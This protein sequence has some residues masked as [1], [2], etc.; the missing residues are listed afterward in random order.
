MAPMLSATNPLNRARG[1][2]GDKSHDNNNEKDSLTHKPGNVAY[3]NCAIADVVHAHSY[4]T[5]GNSFSCPP[6]L[7][8]SP[9]RHPYSKTSMVPFQSPAPGFPVHQ[10]P[11]GRVDHNFCQP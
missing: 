4:L 11:G 6:S 7:L 5:C 9:L 1:S 10:P 3:V 8:S 2:T